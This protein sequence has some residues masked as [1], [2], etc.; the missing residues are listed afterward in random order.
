M[1]RQTKKKISDLSVKDVFGKTYL[2]EQVLE[3][4][5]RHKVLKG[6]AGTGKTYLSSYLGLKS[7]LSGYNDKLVYIRSAVSTRDIGFLPGNEKEKMQVYEAP[8]IDICADLCDRGDAYELLKVKGYVEF[9]PT[10][11]V[12]GITFRNAFIIVDECQNM[13]FHELDSLI[14]RLDDDSRIIFCGDTAQSDLRGNGFSDFS[15][16]LSKVPDVD[17]FNFTIEDIVRS[18]FVKDYLTAKDRMV[19]NEKGSNK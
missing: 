9:K 18:G 6:S 2:Q 16:L 10:S 13:T 12:R 15:N 14:T 1:K 7:V 17:I 5:G 11:F 4:Y 3:S 8:Y 19:N